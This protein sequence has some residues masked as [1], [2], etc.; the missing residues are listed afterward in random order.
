MRVHTLFAAALVLAM[1]TGAAAQTVTVTLESPQAGQVVQSGT[2]VEWQI[3]FTVTAENDGLALLCC[4]LVQNNGNPAFLDIPPA[5]GV[6][7]EMSNFSRPDGVSNPGES[8]PTTGYIGVQRGE[9]GQMNLIQIGGGQNTFG[10]AM[11][12]GFGVAESADVVGGIGQGAPQL[13]GAGSFEVPSVC[14]AYTFELADVLANVLLE[15][16]DPPAYSP[17]TDAAVDAESASFSFTA[18]L[19]GD[20]DGDGDVDHGDLGILLADW[21][22]TGGN[23]PGDCNGDGN[24]DHGD[25]GILLAHWGEVCP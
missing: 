11:P 2:T 8:D 4:D 14:G 15:R 12:P 7:P 10:E 1:A 22:C 5:D 24:T 3:V 9:P 20:L 21:G 23:C 18:T 25:L 13:L 17:V 19:S 16:N 6:P